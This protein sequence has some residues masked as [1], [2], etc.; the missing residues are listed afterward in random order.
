MLDNLTAF[1]SPTAFAVA[2]NSTT[3]TLNS[4]KEFLDSLGVLNKIGLKQDGISIGPQGPIIGGM[5]ISRI[6]DTLADA[7]LGELTLSPTSTFRR[8]LGSEYARLGEAGV[9]LINPAPIPSFLGDKA[10]QFWEL[11]AEPI[12]VPPWQP[13]DYYVGPDGSLDLRSLEADFIPDAPLVLKGRNST[14]G[15][16]IWF[17]PGGIEDVTS[18]WTAGRGPS[19]FRERPGNFLLQY[20]I[21]HRY[22]ARI[23]TAGDTPVSGEDRYGS[24]DT[25]KCNLSVV[26]TGASSALKTARTLL[27]MGAV[28]PIDMDELDPAIETAVEDL[29][30]TLEDRVADSNGP[31]HTWIG[32]DFLVIDPEDPR[33]S[34]V[35][36]DVLE[37]LFHERYR[38][39]RNTYLVF[40]EGNQSPGSKER[41]VNAVSFGREGL[42]WDSAANL[43]TYGECISRGEPFEPGIPELIDPDALKEQ[44]EL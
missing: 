37:G 26:E 4:R 28:D 30:A 25:D 12:P 3:A 34:V 24:P 43:L 39:E 42:R 44:Y 7:G 1:D 14:Q 15:R 6:N 38:T 11:D 10:I 32:W 5:P 21:P 29:H 40:G 20:A 33:L 9:N 31:L 36:E 8:K 35:P 19:V 13:L 23:I 41:Y 16:E 27:S 2:T 22:D 18:D 17:Y